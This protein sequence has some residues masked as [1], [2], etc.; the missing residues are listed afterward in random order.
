MSLRLV[1]ESAPHTQAVTERVFDGGRLVIGR[2]DEADWTLNDPDMFISRQHCILTEKDGRVLAMDASSG[3]LFID[4]AAHPVGASNAVPIEPGMRLRMGDFVL[5]V[6]AV[7]GPAAGPGPAPRP[8]PGPAPGRM[9]FEFGRDAD[10]PPP[11]EPVERPK[12]LPDPFGLASSDRSRERR[13]EPAHQPRPLDQDD[14]FGLDLRK[15]FAGPGDT[16]PAAEPAARSGAGGRSN[17]FGDSAAPLPPGDDPARDRAPAAMPGAKPDLFAGWSQP[18][19]TQPPETAP[20]PEPEPQPE[21]TPEPAPAPRTEPPLAAV[22][23]AEPQRPPLVPDPAPPAPGAEPAAADSDLYAALLRGMGLEPSQFDGDP[24]QQAERIGRSTRLLV[25]GVMLLLRSRAEAKQKAR[26]AQTIIASA[27]VN[28]LKFLASP[29]DVLASF[30]EPQRRGYLAADDAV[31][32]AFRDLADHHLRTWTALQAA[33][34]RMIDRFDPDEIEKAME[35]VGLLESLIAGGRSAKLWRLYQE[36]YREIA[37]AAEDRFLGE[38]GAD[39]RDA[40]ENERRRRDDQS[41]S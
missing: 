24:V 26:V 28:P 14:P 36:R 25:E 30:M 6:E 21:A 13:R 17:Y 7:S 11:P 20:E 19:A 32:E 27:N 18:L 23:K 3:G 22:V 33:L 2:S 35:N 10:E 1:I 40:Y 34:R 16:P 8:A 4:N 5:R 31:N 9:S 12:D 37:R 38:V 29:E 15:A 41:N 39:F